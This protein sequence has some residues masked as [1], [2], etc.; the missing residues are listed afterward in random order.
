VVAPPAD[1][2]EADAGARRLAS[3]LA[4]LRGPFP[5]ASQALVG[6]EARFVALDCEMVGVGSEGRSALALV[7]LCD[8]HGRVLFRSFCRPAEAVTDLRTFVSGVREEHLR[9]APDFRAVQ[10]RVCELLSGKLLVGHGL[11]N[12]LEALLLH[13]DVRARRDTAHYP[14]LM[15]TTA[16]GA[17]KSRKLRDLAKE[18]LGADIQGDGAAHDPAEDARAALAVYK[19]FRLQWERDEARLRARAKGKSKGSAK[20]GARS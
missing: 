20:A 7:V 16:F 13:H 1:A 10:A 15:R 2:A 18:H 4:T 5:P 11:K 6:E 17:L 14:P 3:A 12:D 9:G 8:W 19:V